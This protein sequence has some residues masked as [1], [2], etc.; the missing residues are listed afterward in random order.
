MGWPFQ[1]AVVRGSNL[2]L[3]TPSPGSRAVQF[4]LA[5]GRRIWSFE[6]RGIASSSTLAETINTD[7]D[8][9]L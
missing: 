4:D 2:L 6:F 7:R 9:G 8:E 3:A 1:L 5:T